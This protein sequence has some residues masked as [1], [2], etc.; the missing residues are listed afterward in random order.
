MKRALAYALFAFG[1]P[2][3]IVVITRFV[4]VVR[5]RRT[6]WFAW[7]QAGVAAIVAGQGLLGR[8]SGVAVN[9]A[10]FISAAAWYAL[11]GRKS[12]PELG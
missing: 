5:Q 9:G 12:P 6:R 7:H 3:A 8:A 1:Y 4:P 11:G 10:W 2:T